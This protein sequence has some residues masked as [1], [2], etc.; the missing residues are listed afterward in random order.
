MGAMCSI[1]SRDESGRIFGGRRASVVVKL[2]A[3]L[4][5]SN[6]S[7]LIKNIPIPGTNSPIARA[8]PLKTN[9]PRT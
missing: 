1:R 8:M 2:F 4:C 9:L 5:K 3:Q 6:A 7:R